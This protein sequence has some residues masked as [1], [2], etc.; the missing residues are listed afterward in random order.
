MKSTFLFAAFLSLTACS[1]ID[2]TDY[3]NEVLRRLERIETS[4]FREQRKS[5]AP[6]DTIPQ[7]GEVFCKAFANPSDTTLGVKFLI[8]DTAD[9]SRVNYGYDGLQKAYFEHE[10]KTVRADDFSTLR[11]PFRPLSMPFFNYAEAILRYALTTSDRIETGLDDAGDAMHFRLEIDEE[12]QIEFFGRAY[13]IPAEPLDPRSIYEMWIR[14][15]DMLPFRIRREMEHNTSCITVSDVTINALP[16]TDWL[17][18]DFFPADYTIRWKGARDNV[19]KPSFPI[20]GRKAPAWSLKN[21]AG[22]DISL[23]SFDS[24]VLLINFT[25]IGCGVCI[26]AIPFLNELNERFAPGDFALTAIESW[27]K[28]LHSL[29][30]YSEHYKLKYPLLEGT[31]EVIESY[32]PSTAVPVF[33]LLDCNRTVRRV[34][35]GY[36]PSMNEDITRAIEELIQEAK[37]KA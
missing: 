4:S 35:E 16:R 2:Q 12:R 36:S 6:G 31:A 5:Y 13:R 19:P 23:G 29:R 27:K 7:I 8:Y 26:T 3:L 25:G 11:L 21:G 34:F 33:I 1:G 37:Q 17:L 15:S 22:A 18:T 30:V 28:P 24:S 10:E 32:L 14:K 9:T 20:L